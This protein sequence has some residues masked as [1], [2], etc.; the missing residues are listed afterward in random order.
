[1]YQETIN[2]RFEVVVA[3]N[4]VDYYS[5]SLKVQVNV[6]MGHRLLTSMD[7]LE[8][9]ELPQTFINFVR[10]N[11]KINDSLT[12]VYLMLDKIM[13]GLCSNIRSEIRITYKACHD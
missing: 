10:K 3:N 12:D 5:F 7:Q 2:D 9:G 11:T 8:G 1:T 6:S 4:Y 13:G